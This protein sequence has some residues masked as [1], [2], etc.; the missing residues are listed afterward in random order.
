MP[1]NNPKLEPELL[2]RGTKLLV[3]KLQEIIDLDP[4]IMDIHGAFEAYCM[5]KYSLGNSADNHR[6]GGSNDLGIDFYSQADKVYRVGQCK[7]PAKDWLEANPEQTR[8]FGSQALSDTRDAIRYLLAESEL[9]PNDAVQRLFGHIQGDRNKPEFS[10]KFLVIVYGRLKPRPKEEFLELQAEYTT[11][12]VYVDLIEIDELVDEFLIGIKHTSEQIKF[13]LRIQKGEVI[14]AHRY[15]YFLA[16]A[17]D[18]Y[19]AFMKYGWRLFDLNLRYEVR[20]SPING[21]IVQSLSFSKSRKNFHHYNNGLIIVAKSNSLFDGE[22]R[23]RLVDAQI[24][25]GLQTLKS[26]YNAVVN[27]G[28]TP[29]ELEKECVVQVKV[30]STDDEDFVSKVVRST[31]NQNPMAARNLRSNTREQK[32]LRTGFKMLDPRWFYQL[33][34]EEWKSLTSEGG[35]FFEQVVG[36]KPREFKPDPNRQYGRVIDNQEAA[37][38]WLAFSGFADY[39]GDRVTYFFSD[40]GVYELAFAKRPSLQYWK[41]FANSTDWDATRQSRLDPAQANA[42]QY[43]LA[44]FVWQ[45]VNGF[46]PSPKQYRELGLEEGLRAGRITKASGSFTS[47][48]KDQDAYLGENETYQVWRLMANMKELITETVSQVLT[49]RYGPLDEVTCHRLLKSF[50]AK[51]FLSSGYCKD[52]AQLATFAPELEDREVFARILR[53]IHYVCQQFWEDKKQQLMSASRLRTL[54]L[55]RDIAAS[56]KTL[57]WQTNDRVRLDRPWKP[58]GKTFLDSLPEIQM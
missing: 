13:D 44:F 8:L 35:R 49:R 51:S 21:E 16:N 20:N 6:V 11:R 52:Q 7:I 3:E 15:S 26:I 53:M 4:E 28:T 54:L 10:I 33:K 43:L 32:L 14:R 1:V 19:A 17:S 2:R 48:A 5:L 23:V 41:E 56:L 45:F 18:L 58:E 40:N 50:E 46:V 42:S 12:N 31:N 22:S 29:D 25:N 39:A 24:V 30:I 37:K 55:R 34:E 47:S 27:K 38:A 57:L 36:A 9:K